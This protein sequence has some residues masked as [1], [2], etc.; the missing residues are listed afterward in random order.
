[1]IFFE[2]N[3]K[4]ISLSDSDLL[5]VCKLFFGDFFYGTDILNDSNFTISRFPEKEYVIVRNKLIDYT[6]TILE[7]YSAQLKDS[8]GEC[9]WYN[10][11][12]Y[13]EKLLNIKAISLRK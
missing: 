5:F 6:I 11:L 13:V 9:K 12:T 3:T 1:M 2:I 7:D 10:S 8:S 4:A